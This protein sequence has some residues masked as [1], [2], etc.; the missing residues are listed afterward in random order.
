MSSQPGHRRMLG[1]LDR[2][3]VMLFPWE[4]TEVIRTL[5]VGTWTPVR[6]QGTESRPIGDPGE[7]GSGPGAP[8]HDLTV[9]FELAEGGA[10]DPEEVGEA[11]ERREDRP[12]DDL[13]RAAQERV[14]P[15]PPACGRRHSGVLLLGPLT[16][17]TGQSRWLFSV[18]TGT[19]FGTRGVAYDTLAR[20]SA[21]RRYSERLGSL[22]VDTS[23]VS[24]VAH[25]LH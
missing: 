2:P 5:V 18:S 21:P 24:S 12:V 9:L 10:L 14:P 4:G 22:L 15:S 17:P 23:C 7:L 19:L 3:R 11:L 16:D 1:R 25:A 20:A 13:G 6:Q 8:H